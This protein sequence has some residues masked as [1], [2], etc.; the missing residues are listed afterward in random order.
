[1]SIYEGMFLMDNRQANRD[2]DGSLEKL[3]G[4]F[5]KHGAKTLRSLKWGERR[6]AYEIDGRRRATYVIAYIEAEGQ[7]INS[8]YRECELSELIHRALILKVDKVPAEDEIIASAERIVFRRG[9]RRSQRPDAPSPTRAR[10]AEPRKAAAPAPA[11]K[12]EEP[13]GDAESAPVAKVDKPTVE[14][15]VVEPAAEADAPSADAAPEAA[16]PKTEPETETA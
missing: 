5:A 7:A 16:A 8:I 10:A 2:W 4:Y 3:T 6:L 15:P 14:A 12:A 11:P 1:M 9:D 13:A